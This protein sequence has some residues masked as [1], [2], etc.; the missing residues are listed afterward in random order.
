MEEKKPQSGEEEYDM[1]PRLISRIGLF[2]LELIK[3]AILAGVT[4]AL[5]RHFLF[6]PFYVKGQSMEPTFYE[7]EYL[8]MTNLPTDFENQSVEK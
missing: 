5:V 8:I 7:H 3:I 1:P 2:F 4:I 6:K